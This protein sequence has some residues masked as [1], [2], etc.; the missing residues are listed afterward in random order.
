MR[1]LVTGS[2]G[3]LGANLVARL[4][5]RDDVV[6]SEYHRGC[7]REL[8]K[9]LVGNS[10]VVFHFAGVN[11]PQSEA[12]FAIGNDLLTR[13]VVIAAEQASR[14]I[15]VVLSSS[16]HADQDSPY[17]ISKRSAEDHVLRYENATGS[18]SR[19][20]RLPNIFGKW[21]RPNYNSAVATFCYSIARG[22]SIKIN[23]PDAPLLLAYIDDV[24]EEFLSV[25]DRNAPRR[26]AHW[27]NWSVRPVY[28]VTVGELA[29][30]IKKFSRGRVAACVE[31]VGAGFLRA[32]HATYL[33]FV[34]AESFSFD[35]K[36]HVDHRGE[37]AEFVRTED[38]GQF[39]YFTIRPGVTRGGH[40]HH[41]KSERFLVVRGRAV[42]RFRD[43][44]GGQVHQ[45]EATAGDAPVVETVPGW[46][47]DITN[48][49]DEEVIVILWASEAF[50]PRKPDTVVSSMNL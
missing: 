34:P 50:D 5:E 3:F 25:L 48:I 2:R 42:F 18:A 22:E 39:S 40:F 4:R 24:C 47:H 43:I 30:I 11:R 7:P 15:S 21:S 9:D 32:L 16:I 19:I 33:S 29:D 14:S 1:V 44:R 13:D 38:S 28:E 10:D 6:V 12:E 36:R 37:F 23:D 20:Y 26:R 41:T 49:G 45:I 35:L 8:L 31:R 27:K 17:G 46:A